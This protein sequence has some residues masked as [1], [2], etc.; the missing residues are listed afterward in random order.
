[1]E[2][3]VIPIKT[4]LRTFFRQYVHIMKPVFK[5]NDRES[6]ILGELMYFNYKYRE[7]TEDIRYKIIFDYDTKV[8]IRVNLGITEASFNNGLTTLRKKGILVDNRLAG[9]L[10]VIP[11]S[12]RFSVTFLFS[13]KDDETAS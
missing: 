1:M 9:N 11:D 13:I 10:L 8:E 12:N 4:E 3:K 6:D 5:L 7:L 2:R